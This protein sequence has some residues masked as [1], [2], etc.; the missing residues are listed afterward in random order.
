MSSTLGRRWFG[1]GIL[2]IA[3]FVCAFGWYGIGPSRSGPND[4]SEVAISLATML[5]AA[6][7]VVSRHQNEINDPNV[8]DKGLTSAKVLAETLRLYQDVTGIDPASIDP[9]SRQGRLMKAQLAAITEVIDENQETINKKGIGFKGF[10]PATFARLVNESFSRRAGSEAEVKVTA[11]PDLVRNR[12][13][14]P[15]LWE[16]KV[17]SDDFLKPDW[18]KGKDFSAIADSG[19]RQAF[20]MAVPEYYV[21]SCLACHGTPKGEIDITG[22]PKEGGAVGDLGAVISISLYR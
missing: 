15:D 1:P 16:T 21:A 7:T 18:P 8:G 13:A 9:A 14:R 10:I 3:A 2:M 5:R 22:Y 20:R 4:D 19:G 17:I 12:K 11:P 6:R